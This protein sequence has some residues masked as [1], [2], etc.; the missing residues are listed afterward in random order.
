[1]PDEAGTRLRYLE[2][3]IFSKTLETRAFHQTAHNQ[4]RVLPVLLL[5]AGIS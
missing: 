1:M 3:L 4:V 2:S 5:L